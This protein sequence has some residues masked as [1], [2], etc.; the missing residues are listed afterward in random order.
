MAEWKINLVDLK[1]RKNRRH[2][3]L[4]QKFWLETRHFYSSY[5]LFLAASHFA[6]LILD[7]SKLSDRFFSNCTIVS[8]V[9]IKCSKIPTSFCEH[10]LYFN[11][12][13]SQALLNILS[14]NDAFAMHKLT[15]S[16]DSWQ[17]SYNVIK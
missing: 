5:R 13:S 2:C 7:F 17:F 10:S 9:C 8:L 15:N 3:G 16:N 4:F 6:F 1:E 14:N 11:C 12:K